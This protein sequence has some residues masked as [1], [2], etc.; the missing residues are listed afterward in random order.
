MKPV[1][2]K[3]PIRKKN[4]KVNKFAYL[5]FLRTVNFKVRKT[6]RNQLK[7]SKRFNIPNAYVGGH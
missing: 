3:A 6:I 2:N 5:Y 4:S 1:H 7:L